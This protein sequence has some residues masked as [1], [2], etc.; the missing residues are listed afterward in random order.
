[1]TAKLPDFVL[2]H[3][4][5]HMY[6]FHPNT[7]NRLAELYEKKTRLVY[8]TSAEVAL[9]VLLRKKLWM[10][11]VSCMND[12]LEV[13]HGLQCLS[14]AYRGDH[15]KRLQAVLNS[16][17]PGI[18]TEIETKFDE[19]QNELRY[20][21]FIICL[22]EHAGPH[23]EDEDRVGRLSMWRAYGR[24]KGVALVFKQDPIWL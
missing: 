3:I 23:R 22:S 9:E 4:A 20:D 14:A 10:R 11:Q 5:Q 7:V 16:F 21:T 24:G 8:Y 15:G 13:Q 18:S 17:F 12:Y 1:M 6:A 2:P 19:R